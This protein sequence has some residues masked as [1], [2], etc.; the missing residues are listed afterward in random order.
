M[1]GCK[2]EE[3]ILRMPC[4][5][6]QWLLWEM[7]PWNEVQDNKISMTQ[8]ANRVSAS[9]RSTEGVKEIVVRSPSEHV[10]PLQ[11]SKLVLEQANACSE[12]PSGS[13]MWVGEAG[14]RH[15]ILNECSGGLTQASRCRVLSAAIALT[16]AGDDACVDGIC[17]R[18][19][20]LG[21]SRV[22]ETRCPVVGALVAAARDDDQVRVHVD[23]RVV[24]A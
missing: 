9:I 17:A 3:L 11:K 1:C 15:G 19:G 24:G 18:P 6:L 2:R 14:K 5:A 13:R 16:S 23:D 7:E 21:F 12:S 8:A 22:Q 10:C 4:R 20:I